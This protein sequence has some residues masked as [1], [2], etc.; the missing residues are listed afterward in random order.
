MFVAVGSD[1]IYPNIWTSTNAVNWTNRSIKSPEGFIGWARAVA[2]GNGRFVVAG[3]FLQD[4]DL[5]FGSL[6][7][8]SSNAVDW[9]RSPAWFSALDAVALGNDTFLAAGRMCIRCDPYAAPLV[10]S[11]TG[12]NWTEQQSR[13]IRGLFGI[14]YGKGTFVLVGEYG[15][16]LQSDPFPPR[17]ELL[18]N[19]VKGAFAFN[20]FGEAGEHYRIEVSSDLATWSTLTNFVSVSGSNLFSDPVG[21]ALSRRFYRAVTP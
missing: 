12:S 14:T 9:V 6:I 3:G 17:L 2:Y 5:L 16:I 4:V 19:P 13:T 20:L 11:N 10:S 1:G 7:W 15:T 8:T 21:Q 18:S